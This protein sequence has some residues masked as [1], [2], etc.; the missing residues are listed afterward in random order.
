MLFN[1]TAKAFWIG[2][3]ELVHNLFVFDEQERWHRI[4]P[5]SL[6]NSTLSVH[7]DFRE[8]DMSVLIAQLS[9][10]W[11]NRQA[12]PAPGG[13]EIHNHQSTGFVV[14]KGVELCRARYVFDER[15][16]DQYAE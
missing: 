13:M 10:S 12:W 8:C 7:I 6:G 11:C 15:H 14:E 16:L 2:A 9:E 3:R 1:Q 5:V 4:Y